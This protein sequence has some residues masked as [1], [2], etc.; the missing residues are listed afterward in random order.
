MINALHL[1]WIV[2]AGIFVGMM[3]AALVAANRERRDE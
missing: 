3:L 1:A 2:P